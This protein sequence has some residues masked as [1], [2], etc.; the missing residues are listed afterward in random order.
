VNLRTYIPFGFWNETLNAVGISLTVALNILI[1]SLI[2]F[3]LLRVHKRLS[4][5]L[6]HYHTRYHERLYFGIVAILVE[7]AAP[8]GVFGIG[9]VITRLLSQ[10]Y[11]PAWKAAPVFNT[12]YDASA[13]RLNHL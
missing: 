13:V 10:T 3:R 5:A 11:D 4:M 8:L 12:L 6:P 9:V 1:T 7:S 2:T